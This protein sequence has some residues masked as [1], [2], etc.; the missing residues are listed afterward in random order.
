MSREDSVLITLGAPFFRWNDTLFIEDQTIS[1][2]HAWADHFQKVVAASVCLA[3]KPPAG[4]SDAKAAGIAAPAI[5]IVELPNGYDRATFRRTRDAVAAQFL[6]IMR[7][8]TFRLFAIGGWLGDWGVLGADTARKHG[9]PHGIWFDRVESQVMLES[10][11]PGLLARLKGRVKWAVGRRNETRVLRGA[12]LALL[13]GRTVYDRLAPLTRNPHIV[14][15]IHLSEADHIAPDQLAQKRAQVAQGPLRIVY[16][17]RATAMK[18]PLAW[19]EALAGLSERGVDWQADWLGDGDLLDEMQTKARDMG[20]VHRITFHGFV[21][22]RATVL[23]ALRRA[24]VL[25]FCHLTD[26]SPRILI[27]ALHAGT[28]LVGY[29]D[30]FADSLVEEQGAG[31]LVTRGD[32]SALQEAIAALESDRVRLSDLIRRAA[33]SARHLTR[34]KVFAHRCEIIK[35][36]LK[37]DPVEGHH[38]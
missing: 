37:R 5:E 17:G 35:Q 24:H 21:A 26:E 10:A 14:E 15:D 22:D 8:V 33:A 19:L 11:G 2:L 3:E 1:G 7:R 13:H 9:I 34:E 23:D 28:P 31:C 12:D 20:L 16:A 29:R 6:D 27:E 4:W 30:P 25:L 38:G 32:I 36:N 18:G